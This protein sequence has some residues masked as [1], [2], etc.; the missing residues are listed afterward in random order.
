[1]SL[2]AAEVQILARLAKVRSP[3]CLYS[4]QNIMKRFPVPFRWIERI[5]LRRA[6][7]IHA[8]NDEVE[9][10][11]R[12]KGFVGTVRNLGLGIDTDRFSP[13]EREPSRTIR[14]GYCG[15]LE[16]HKG[17]HILVSALE[18]LPH[19]ELVIVG[20]GPMRA[21]LEAQVR[22]AHLDD[23]VEFRGAVEYDLLPAEYRSF[24]VLAVP[25]L[26]TRSWI[27]QF[28]RVA[29][30][31]MACGV[32]VVASAS[33]AL[34][35]VVADGGV[36]VPPGDAAALAGGIRTLTSDPTVTHEF[37]RRARDRAQRFSWQS[38]ATQ[39]TA[40]YSEMFVDAG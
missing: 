40:L 11:V 28:G 38:V 36:L 33:G 7:A 32:P 10:I 16:E 8:C 18:L 20:T 1:V 25:S 37:G 14:V 2:A 34:P 26:T 35:E 12:S 13:E 22:A 23:R 5:A 24:D 17:V 19:H 4:A 31:A 21:R 30:E 15:R 39:H 3:F 9:R 29:V 6:T 27:E